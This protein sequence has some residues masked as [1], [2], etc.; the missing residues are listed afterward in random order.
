MGS[1]ETANLAFLE[2]LYLEFCGEGHAYRSIQEYKVKLNCVNTYYDTLIDVI[3]KMGIDFDS[4]S[5]NVVDLTN[6]CEMCGFINGIEFYKR[7]TDG[8][9]ELKV[10]GGGDMWH[11]VLDSNHPLKKG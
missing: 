11:F 3:T 9:N 5:D 2:S 6:A 10:G 7:L 4:I 1:S 8:I